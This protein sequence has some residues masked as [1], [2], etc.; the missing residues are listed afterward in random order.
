MGS[1]GLME[2][3]T[4]FFLKDNMIKKFNWKFKESDQLSK[5]QPEF[6]PVITELMMK[7]GQKN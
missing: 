6:N 2:E 5:K 3:T 7:H 4:L 1:E